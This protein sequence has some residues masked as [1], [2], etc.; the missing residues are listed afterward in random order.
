MA[1]SASTAL[2]CSDA[3][4]AVT[5]GPGSGGFAASGAFE[6]EA[7]RRQTGSRL[8]PVTPNSS[9][10]RRCSLICSGFIA[11]ERRT[12]LGL[13]PHRG[14]SQEALDPVKN[15]ARDARLRLQRNL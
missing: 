10:N 5:T 6:V 11:D 15:G 1:A 14:T 13:D 4:C 2:T 7:R 8:T 12:R 3:G 9:A